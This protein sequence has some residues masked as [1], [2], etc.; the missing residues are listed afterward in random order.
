M[1]YVSYTLPPVKRR[2]YQ[3]T[4]NYVPDAGLAP[5]KLDIIAPCPLT[6]TVTLYHEFAKMV[7]AKRIM[8]TSRCSVYDTC[9]SPLRLL[10]RQVYLINDGIVIICFTD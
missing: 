3:C 7:A 6:K 4:C 10:V 8:R 1:K 5:P 2:P 9:L